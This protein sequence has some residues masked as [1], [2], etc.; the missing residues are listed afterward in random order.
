MIDGGNDEPWPQELLDVL[1]EFQQG[2][3][4]PRPPFAYHAASVN[5]IWAATRSAAEAA[6]D[7]ELLVE[8]DPSDRPAFGIVT[9]QSCDID[10]RGAPR[11]PWVQL[12]PVYEL[13]SDDNRLPKARHWKVSYLAP[14]TAL[15]PDWVADLRIE[16]PV[17]KSWL[18]LQRPQPAFK[19]EV[20]F[21]KFSNHCGFIR[22]RPAVANEVEEYI[23]DRLGES[24]R[25]LRKAERSAYD[26]FVAHVRR[27]FLAVSGDPLSPHAVQ[28]VFVSSANPFPPAVRT[29]LENWWE[30]AFAGKIETGFTVLPSQ[31]LATS[32]SVPIGEQLAWVEWDLARLLV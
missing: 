2:S 27:L 14:T 8:L 18:V 32:D 31:L 17:E 5:P 3:L 6:T 15:G 10:E 4:V 23:L 25:A 9:T 16:F 1:V 13:R 28:L 26:L 12:A 21:A 20:E 30:D 22:Q 19:N 7:R 29:F 24:L 11:R